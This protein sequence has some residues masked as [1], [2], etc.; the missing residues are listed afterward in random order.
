MS[1]RRMPGIGLFVVA[2][3]A[4]VVGVV[5]MSGGHNKPGWGLIGIGAVVLIAGLISFFLAQQEKSWTRI[6][7]YL[8]KHNRRLKELIFFAASS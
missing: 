4:V 8:A 3:A 1:N 6:C 7:F 5:L 2:V